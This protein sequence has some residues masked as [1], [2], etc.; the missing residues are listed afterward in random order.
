MWLSNLQIKKTVFSGCRLVLAY[1]VWLLGGVG[2]LPDTAHA[3]ALTSRMIDLR[4]NMGSAMVYVDS[5]Y[6]GRVSDQFF[7]VPSTAQYLILVPPSIDSWAIPPLESNLQQL[8]GDT[9]KMS[10]DFQYHYRVESIPYDAQVFVET[11]GDRTLLGDTPMLQAFDDP[12]RGMLL[13]VKDGYEP[14][15]LTPGEEIWNQHHV[16]LK[17]KMVEDGP[18]AFWKPGNKSSRW[19]SMLA[20]G[21]ALASG[22]LAVHY[23][24][25]ADRR[26]A[27]YEET[28]DPDLRPGFER[29]DRYAGV[30]LGTMQVGIGVLAVRLVLN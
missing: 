3:Q 14:L 10:L 24:F 1:M 27:R 8:A 12:I 21:V 26:Y 17:E 4:S 2:V 23:K 30:A 9:L 15:R 18:H 29:Y 7:T 22:A 25:K 16:S 28:G 11:P 19:V 20:G 5:V 13:V 6:I